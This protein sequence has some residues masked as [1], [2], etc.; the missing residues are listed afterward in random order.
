[1][2]NA[3]V[4][5]RENVTFD[6]ELLMHRIGLNHYYNGNM[7]VANEILL[8]GIEIWNVNKISTISWDGFGQLNVLCG[9][10]NL[11]NGNIEKAKTT[12][13]KV[14]S[15]LDDIDMKL[16]QTDEYFIY[17]YLYLYY[18]ELNQSSKAF[19]NLETAYNNI[20]KKQIDQYNNHPE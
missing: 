10:T 20:D 6:E 13:A 15:Q 17:Y 12:I 9:L 18:N 3:K 5:G 19:K 1:M 8:E 4:L 2:E 11:M 16:E 14:D 7:K